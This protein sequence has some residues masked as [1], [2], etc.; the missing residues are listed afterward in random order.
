MGG[1]GLEP[2]RDSSRNA[3]GGFGWPETYETVPARKTAIGRPPRVK[4]GQRES[5]RRAESSRASANRARA[6]R[7][8]SGTT[9]GSWVC[10]AGPPAGGACPRGRRE[11][12]ARRA[13]VTG[14]SEDRVDEGRDRARLGQDDEEGQAADH[15]HDRRDPPDPVLAEEAEELHRRNSGILEER[16]DER[17]DERARGGDDQEGPDRDHHDQQGKH[18]PVAA[19]AERPEQLRGRPEAPRGL[20][21]DEP[22]EGRDEDRGE[23][24]ERLRRARDAEEEAADEGE[25]EGRLERGEEGGLVLVGDG[26]AD[27]EEEPDGAEEVGPGRLARGSMGAEVGDERMG[28]PGHLHPVED[29]ELVQPLV[30]GPGEG[31]VPRGGEVPVLL[32]VEALP[33]RGARAQL[34]HRAHGED[35]RGDAALE[36]APGGAVGV[37]DLRGEAVD[38]LVGPP[39]VLVDLDL[40]RDREAGG[41]DAAILGGLREDPDG[42]V[43]PAPRGGDEGGLLL[44]EDPLL[45]RD[46]ARE[47]GGREARRGGPERP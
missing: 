39:R 10:P 35:L 34:V 27:G 32:V 13:P 15:D 12:R 33:P 31:T 16:V 37:V 8:P 23:P 46:R 29:P 1:G 3:W 38:P 45:L 42:G 17:G 5:P 4:Y 22:E 9:K 19:P 18:I 40:V 2:G 14:P 6:A 11:A 20:P 47:P 43:D 30:E 26:V 21:E 25:E 24:R 36:E 41:A 7:S 44:E 28:G